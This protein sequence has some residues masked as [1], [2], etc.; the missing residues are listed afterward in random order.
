L[1]IIQGPFSVA[2]CQTLI[3]RFA[4]FPSPYDVAR[5]ARRVVPGLVADRASRALPRVPV[6][7]AALGALLAQGRGKRPAL[8]WGPRRRLSGVNRHPRH[9]RG[10]GGGG[11]GGGWMTQRVRVRSS[12]SSRS[13]RSSSRSSSKW[14][15][16]HAAR[17]PRAAAC[18]AV[19]RVVVVVVVGPHR[20]PRLQLPHGRST[21]HQPLSLW[22]AAHC[23]PRLQL[24]LPHAQ[25]PRRRRQSRMRPGA[26]VGNMARERARGLVR[27]WEK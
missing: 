16:P 20:A 22:A 6:A 5:A 19:Q 11:G 8:G 24:R 1:S 2:P 4:T 9:Q 21:H 14:R 23:A 12:S 15:R 26:H 3:S 7:A 17:Y 25:L 18:R 13:S 10:G 27:R